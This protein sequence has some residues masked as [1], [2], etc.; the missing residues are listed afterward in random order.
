VSGPK[1]IVSD[2]ITGRFDFIVVDERDA[3]FDAGFPEPLFAVVVSSELYR[4]FRKQCPD[5]DSAELAEACVE[6]A[7]K[8][9]CDHFAGSSI[10]IESIGG[11]K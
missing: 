7:K 9:D 2:L 5:A 11:G 4:R 1:L 6:H 3:V 10:K 8:T